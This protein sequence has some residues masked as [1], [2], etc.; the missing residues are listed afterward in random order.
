MANRTIK[1]KAFSYQVVE[2]DPLDPDKKV[3]RDKLARRGVEVDIP[4]DEDLRRGELHGAFV[5]DEDAS[6]PASPASLADK[7]DEELVD[8][9][10]GVGADK[11]PNVQDVIEASGGD[12]DLA[13]RL[14]VAEEEASDGEPRAGVTEGLGKIIDAGNQ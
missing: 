9:L 11:A 3:L 6:E 10:E 12:V 1:H 2:P 7:T 14:L 4:R 8:Y 13:R 5:S